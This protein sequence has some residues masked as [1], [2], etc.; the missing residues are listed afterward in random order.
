M[1]HA[2]FTKK[3]NAHPFLTIG[4]GE[5]FFYKNRGE[6]IYSSHEMWIAHQRKSSAPKL[7]KL[8]NNDYFL[9]KVQAVVEKEG[10]IEATE[11]SYWKIASFSQYLIDQHGLES[12]LKLYTGSGDL[13]QNVEAGYGKSLVELEKDW[14]SYTK[15]LETTFPAKFKYQLGE[16]YKYWYEN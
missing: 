8:M 1:L 3:T 14:I 12:F 9:K 13:K 2:L 11:A 16:D 7:E 6:E 10:P 15:N 5:Y 4:V